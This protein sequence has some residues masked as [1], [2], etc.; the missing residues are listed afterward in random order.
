MNQCDLLQLF[1]SVFVWRRAHTCVYVSICVNKQVFGHQLIDNIDLN[2]S[3]LLLLS[4]HLITI[5]TEYSRSLI[6]TD[7]TLGNPDDFS[8]ILLEM[9][10]IFQ[11]SFIYTKM[12]SFFREILGISLPGNFLFGFC[13]ENPDKPGFI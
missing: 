6:Q 5:Q 1:M 9:V 7:L 2:K 8:N 11:L 3:L 12:C 13:N 10:K 4:V